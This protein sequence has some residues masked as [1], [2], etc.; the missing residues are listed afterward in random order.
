MISHEYRLL[1]KKQLTL[2]KRLEVLNTAIG[3]FKEQ[4]QNG[5]K[6]F[7]QSQF[8]ERS[9]FFSD[10]G[11]KIPDVFNGSSG[12]KIECL[13]EMANEILKE[14]IEV[15]KKIKIEEVRRR[16]TGEFTNLKNTG[17]P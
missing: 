10:T 14:E 15:S 17:H 7:V 2:L 4:R 13:Q 8:P 6:T 1:I 16:L 5:I 3:L 12:A 11:G 9:Q